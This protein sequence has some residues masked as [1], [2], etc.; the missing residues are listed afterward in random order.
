MIKN[1]NCEVFRCNLGDC[2][3]GGASS[4]Y[5]SLILWDENV[6]E[7]EIIA[8]CK[9]KNENLERHFRIEKRSAMSMRFGMTCTRVLPVPVK[10]SGFRGPMFGGNFVYSS[11]SRFTDLTGDCVPVAIHDR[12][13]QE[14]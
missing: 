14:V 9:E 7:D 8:F 1:L 3:N 11:D 5:G 13:E 4:K 12:Y 10:K 6:P 2:S